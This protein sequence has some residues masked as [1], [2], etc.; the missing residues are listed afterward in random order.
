[1][2]K[3]KNS[4]SSDCVFYTSAGKGVLYAGEN[5]RNRRRIPD[6]KI[7]TVRRHCAET[8][9]T[10]AA[11]GCAGIQKKGIPKQ[12]LNLSAGKG[13]R[14]TRLILASRS[15]GIMIMENKGNNGFVK[16]KK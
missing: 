6:M 1:M 10:G 3:Y 8:R 15:N 11:T 4:L 16:N 5:R 7:R 9:E 12:N 14:S 13:D 2:R